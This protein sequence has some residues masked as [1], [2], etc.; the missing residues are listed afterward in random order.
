MML[1]I[2]YIIR[3]GIKGKQMNAAAAVLLNTL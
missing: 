2:I 1:D 3:Y